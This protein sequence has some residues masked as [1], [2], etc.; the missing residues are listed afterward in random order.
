M[1]ILCDKCQGK[2]TLPDEKLPAGKTLSL[3]CPKCENHLQVTI[4]AAE[5]AFDEV[6]SSA[7]PPQEGESNPIGSPF[8]YVEEGVQ[9][10]LL[11]EPDPEIRKRLSTMLSSSAGYWL[12]EAEDARSALRSLRYHVYDLVVVNEL[13]GTHNPKA[14]GV[15]IFMERLEMVVRRKIFVALLSRRFRSMDQMMAFN[16]SVDMIINLEDLSEF[17]KILARGQREKAAFYK[18]F[19]D[20]LKRAG[21]L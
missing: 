20:T 13:F 2:F 10:V 18:V 11:C 3:K 1:N 21:R 14:N 19:M 17:D 7:S 6:E 8:G 16:Q 12:T 9:T 5:P 4:P 15:L